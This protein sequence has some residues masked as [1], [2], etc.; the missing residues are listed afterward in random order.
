MKSEFIQPRFDGARFAEHTLPLDVA[1]DLRAYEELVVELA[2]RLYLKEHPSRQRVPKGFDAD[3]H[4]HL[5]KLDPGSSRPLLSLVS[6]GSLLLPGAVGGYFERSRDLINECIAAEQG[7]LPEEFPRELLKYFNRLGRSLKEDEAVDFSTEAGKAA[8]LTP[9]RRKH[10]VL[11]ADR[12]YE[13]E[14]ELN[15]FVEEADWQKST[16]RL[17]LTDGSKVNVPMPE[18]FHAKMRE[19]GGHKRYLITVNGIGAFDEWDKL[20]RVLS[21]D[22]IEVQPNYELNARFDELRELQDGWMDGAG[23][24]PDSEALEVVASQTISEFPENASLP[25]IVPTPE[26]DLLFEWNNEMAPSVDFLLAE[27][28]AIFHAFRPDGSEVEE[29]LDLTQDNNW[30]ELFRLIE[31]FANEEGQA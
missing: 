24:A 8:V 27:N 15:G 28:K 7:H 10:L 20:R 31:A 17:R 9:E 26:G 23:K 4:L 12:E 16:F 19:V 1:S 6:A 30:T 29:T 25:A 22:S 11:A 21:A 13:R 3:F 2:K 18:S 14:I 5:E